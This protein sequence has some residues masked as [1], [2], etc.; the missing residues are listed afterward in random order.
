MRISKLIP[1][2]SI[3]NQSGFTL[4]EALVS[5]VLSGFAI[6]GLIVGYATM[7]QRAEYA[8][9]STS[10]MAICQQG[11]EMSR[12]AKWDTSSSPEIDELVTG[13]FPSYSVVMDL[14]M[15]ATVEVRGTNIFEIVKVSQNPPIKKVKVDTIWSMDGGTTLFTNTMVV[16]RAPDQ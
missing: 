8:V 11:I 3:H 1:Q 2:T 16:L 7:A 14:N 15:D 13:N 6:T 4:L 10:A 12:A 9:Y 5:T